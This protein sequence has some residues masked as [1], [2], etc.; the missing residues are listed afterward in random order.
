MDHTQQTPAEFIPVAPPPPDPATELLRALTPRLSEADDRALA[1]RVESDFHD[2]IQDRAEWENR[3]VEWEDAYYGRTVEKDFPWPGASNFHV[4]ITM[5]GVETYK[6]RLVEAVL[7]QHPPIIVVP[8]TQAGEEHRLKVETV[9]NWQVVSQMK[10][11]P[12]VVESAH[13]FLQ[14]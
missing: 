9:I 12:T 1:A 14:P 10:L 11:E 6:P 3:L 13:L 5:M 4:P 7:G 8:T 2:A